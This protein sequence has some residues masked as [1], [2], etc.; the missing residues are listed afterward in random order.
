MPS[1]VYSA[2]VVGV[3]AFEVEIEVHAGWGNTDKIAM[4]GLPDTAV[5]E[6]K[7]R[8][9]SAICNSALRWPSGKR[10]TINLAP[11]DVRK[12][13]PSFDLPIAVGMLKL[14]E[15]NR[16]PEL[17]AFCISGEL[18]LSGQLRPMKGVLSI[19][20]EAKRRR[21][22][23]LIVPL[24][25]AVEAAV[26]EGVDVYG[27]CSLSEVVQFLRGEKSLEPVRSTGGWSA[28]G[29]AE[30]ELDFGE[31]KGQQHVKRAVEVAAAGGHNILTIGPVPPRLDT[32]LLK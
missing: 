30:Q 9:T 4:V 8:V 12:E 31:V 14:E 13:G 28:A 32:T 7:D 3:E 25:N 24:D 27:V 17:S 10:I 21:R 22:Q 18:A 1:K 5:K 23:T 11:A 6:S 26:V 19:A 29:G 16:L 20:L 2:A 15:N